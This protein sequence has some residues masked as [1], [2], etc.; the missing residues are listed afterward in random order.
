MKTTIM[1]LMSLFLILAF[2]ASCGKKEG[3][4]SSSTNTGSNYESG[5]TTGD[6]AYNALKT[7]LETADSTKSRPG[8]LGFYVRDT[9][10]PVVTSSICPLNSWSA[11]TTPTHCFEVTSI[12]VQIG[13]VNIQSGSL[14]TKK[15]NGC[16]ITSS[17]NLYEKANDQKLKDAILGTS[18]LFV[19]KSKTVQS[20]SLFRVFYSSTEGSVIAVK[21][22]DINTSL[23][24]IMNPTL[25]PQGTDTV[26]LRD[27]TLYTQNQYPY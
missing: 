23:P 26:K 22:A 18:T 16:T 3:G 21:Y 4:S 8:V 13:Q 25:A 12:G 6:T 9:A 11:C 15:L 19:I 1:H 14:G 5:N 24:A 7:W 2:S 17:M 10:S 27:H 20:G